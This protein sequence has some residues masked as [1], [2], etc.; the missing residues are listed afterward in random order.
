MTNK[1][2]LG[3]ALAA[4]MVATPTL[5][6]ESDFGAC[7]VDEM[8]N[9]EFLGLDLNDDTGL[10]MDEY[11]SCL[12]DNGIELSDADM[13][14]FNAAYTD[15]DA[16]GDGVLMF[17]EVQTH[18]SAASGG[19]TEVAAA[20]TEDDGEA[21]QGTVTVTQPAAEVTVEQPAAEVTVEQPEP[22]VAV[23]QTEP[24]V[25]VETEAPD[26]AVSQPEPE[27]SVEQAEPQVSVTQPEPEV[28]VEQ[29]EAQVAVQ[30][31]TPAV[32]VETKQPEVAVDTPDPEVE[33]EEP[34]LNVAVEQETPEVAVEQESADVAVESTTTAE[35]AETE[36][37]VA[38][39]TTPTAASSVEADAEAMKT[40]S[41][42]VRIAELEG[43]DVMNRAGE[44]IGEIDT[45]LLDPSTN[46]PVVIVSVGGVLGIGD[47][48]IA[49]PYDD[50]TITGEEVVLDT[51]LSE[52]QIEDMDEYNEADY[53]DLPET[54]IVR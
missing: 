36:N 50:F 21:P 29:P 26:V 1:W 30:A 37:D 14:A 33:V 24:Q 23:E 3:T 44:E 42:Q 38:A 51:D 9:E 7:A 10:S 17:A 41:Y 45:V 11:R 13:T 32:A 12:E 4:M 48:E 8:T 40:A 43:A 18:A 6:Q 54:M 46:A 25:E 20:D 35:P 16:N 39:A 34:E 22:Q 2:M 27:V 49:F 19:G 5:A 47:K 28:E 52:D 31:G 53:Q 15:A